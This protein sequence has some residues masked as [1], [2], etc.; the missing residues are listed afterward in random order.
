MSTVS[1][2]MPGSSSMMSTDAVVCRMKTV[3]MPARS[4]LP[5]SACCTGCVMFSHCVPPCMETRKGIVLTGILLPLPQ[6]PQ[7]LP[8]SARDGSAARFR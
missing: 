6:P 8:L 3:T 4:A 7:Q 1:A 2:R 5:D